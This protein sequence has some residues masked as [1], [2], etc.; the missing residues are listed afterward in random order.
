MPTPDIWSWLLLVQLHKIFFNTCPLLISQMTHRMVL[1]TIMGLGKSATFFAKHEQY[2]TNHHTICGS[3]FDSFWGFA[4]MG[5]HIKQLKKTNSA[6]FR[7]RTTR[8]ICTHARTHTQRPDSWTYC[9]QV[10]IIV[11]TVTWYLNLPSA[12]DYHYI[13]RVLTAEPT[14]CRWSTLHK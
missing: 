3:Q 9:L 10:T 7:L 2:V 13:H 8:I 1:E 11:Q 4:D 5:Q 12:G 14:V 6:N